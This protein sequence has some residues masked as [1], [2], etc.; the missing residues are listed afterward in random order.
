MAKTVTISLAEHEYMTN[1]IAHDGMTIARLE[2]ELTKAKMAI[3]RLL[4]VANSNLACELCS[5]NPETC[6]GV[7]E[8]TADWNGRSGDE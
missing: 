2:A 3:R 1:V 7:C 5:H 8:L 6:G 4:T